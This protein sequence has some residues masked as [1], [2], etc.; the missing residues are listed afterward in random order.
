MAKEAGLSEET[1]A[2]IR[3]KIFGAK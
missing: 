2:T 1:A 3:A